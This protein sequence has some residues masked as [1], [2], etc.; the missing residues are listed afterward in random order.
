[1]AY[2]SIALDAQRAAIVQDLFRLAFCRQLAENGASVSGCGTTEAWR[3]SEGEL[4]TLIEDYATWLRQ[5]QRSD[6]A[7]VLL[8]S[9]FGSGAA[10]ALT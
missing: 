9:A 4:T 10:F 5:T 8:N 6:E 3:L 2:A 1:M 7:D